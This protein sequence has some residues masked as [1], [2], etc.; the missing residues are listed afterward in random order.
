MSF[1]ST[2]LADSPV[3]YIK[4]TETSGTT[5]SDTSGNGNTGTYN[6]CTLN[7]TGLIPSES[8][9]CVLFDGTTSFV[10]LGNPSAL[11]ILGAFAIEAI[12]SVN[13]PG[14]GSAI[15]TIGGKGYDGTN[16][17]FL[18]LAFNLSTSDKTLGGGVY[19]GSDGITY[20]AASAVSWS[21]GDVHIV[22]CQYTGTQWELYID[23]VLVNTAPGAVGQLASASNFY[24]GAEDRGSIFGPFAGKIEKVSIY[25]ASLSAARW[26][27]HA[28]AA[29]FNLPPPVLSS[30][31]VPS[32]GEKISLT[33]SSTVTGLSL[34]D[35]AST[36][37]S[38][39]LPFLSLTGSGTS[40]AL[41]LGPVFIG[42]GQVVKVAYAGS[43]VPAITLT[44]T[45]SSAVP[46]T[47]VRYNKLQF[48]AFITWSAATF[49]AAV[50]PVLQ[51]A[52]NV[53]FNPASYSMGNMLDAAQNMGAKYIIFTAKH[54]ASFCLWPTL[55]GAPNIG[56]TPWYASHKIDIVADY[57]T[58]ARQRGLGV[59][60][61]LNFYD[62]WFTSTRPGANST[63]TNTAPTFL[64]YMSQQITELLS[65]YGQIDYLWIDSLYTTGYTVA[66]YAS[67][68]S[69]VTSL[70]PNCILINNAHDTVINKL[71]HSDIAEYEDNEGLSPDDTTIVASEFCQPSRTD[72]TWVWVAAGEAYIDPASAVSKLRT[73]NGFHSNFLLNITPNDQGVIPPLQA[74]F[75]SAVGKLL[76]VTPVPSGGA[77]SSQMLA[78]FMRHRH[79]R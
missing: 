65:N 51:S 35:F 63:Y 74:A 11:Q 26:S 28:Q 25:N 36:A 37:D 8:D 45:N 70:Q 64:E 7:Q 79:R 12:L 49:P 72:D 39:S 3:A 33:F 54:G 57:V 10:D 30:A 44:A 56:P 60:L 55:S 16:Q 32:T 67:L 6:N 46:M 21:T 68:R 27:A 77:V 76:G 17:D 71:V 15:Y 20:A 4:L 52:A 73:L 18:R 75:T 29:G 58:R 5:A 69:L 61:Y 19:Q 47:I 38:I 2:V 1:D 24:I 34:S 50:D 78:M 13:F 48:G 22:A 62:S 23:G 59:G 14:S 53:W 43:V 9:K 41:V 42:I 31:S 40:W 66:P